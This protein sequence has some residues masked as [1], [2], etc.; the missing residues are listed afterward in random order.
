MRQCAGSS[1]SPLSACSST[2][3]SEKRLDFPEPLAPIR[4]TRSPWWRVRSAL[5]R[6]T[7]APRARV[8]CVKRIKLPILPAAD[9]VPGLLL[10]FQDGDDVAPLEARQQE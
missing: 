4:P 8:S 1:T 2:R 9:L 10:L 7:F 3:K 6:R 5:S